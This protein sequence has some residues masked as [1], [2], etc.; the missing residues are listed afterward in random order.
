MGE[1]R[2]LH[3]GDFD[4]FY[5]VLLDSF[6]PDELRSRAEHKALLDRP[7]YRVYAHYEEDE[8]LAFLT[9]W[10]MEGFSFVEHFAVRSDRR[11]SGLG[12][13]LLGKLQSTL[14]TRLFL[15]AELPDTEL[16]RRRIGFYER[17][18]FYKNDYPYIQPP[19]EPGK[20]PVPMC[21]MTTHGPVDER[22]FE[23]LRSSLYN[24]VYEGK[25]QSS[26]VI[27]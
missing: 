24:I 2:R 5:E 4:R 15:E 17:N 9:V 27:R 22:V 19:M 21:I 11:G 26:T 13:R 20:N 12:S 23:K 8:L 18:G 6:P 25:M 7:D 14:K 3:T 10:T 1:L 16:A